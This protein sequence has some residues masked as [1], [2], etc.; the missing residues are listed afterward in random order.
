VFANFD[1]RLL[2]L[3]LKYLVYLFETRFICLDTNGIVSFVCTET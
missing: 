1:Q 3:Y 2:E